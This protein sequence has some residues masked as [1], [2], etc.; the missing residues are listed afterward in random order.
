[1][2]P[3]QQCDATSSGYNIIRYKRSNSIVVC[4]FRRCYKE[5]CCYKVCRFSEGICKHF[6]CFRVNQDCKIDYYDTSRVS[7]TLMLGLKN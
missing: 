2:L 7:L 1:M 4:Y 5:C 3:D 6:S